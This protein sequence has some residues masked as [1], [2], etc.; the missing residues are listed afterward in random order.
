MTLSSLMTIDSNLIWLNAVFIL[1]FKPFT[2]GSMLFIL[3]LK[4][5]KIHLDK[6]EIF[7]ILML[8]Y[9]V[10]MFFEM[11]LNIFIY[12]TLEFDLVL[13][14][15]D[16][17]ISTST[18]T[19]TNTNTNTNTNDNIPRTRD[20]PDYARLIRYLSANIG[21]LASKRPVTRAIGLTIANAGNI[22]ADIASNEE[23]ANYW[24]DQYN[25]YKTNGRFRGGQPGSGPF[26]RGSNPFD[27][28]ANIGNSDT[29]NFMPNFEFIRD[30]LSPVEHSIPLDTL[31][32]VHFI[33]ILGLFVI[34]CALILLT[35]YVYIQILI[36][37][38]KDFILN[39]IKNRYAVM[40]VKYVLFKSRV[41]II[42]MSIFIL[43]TLCFMVY[44]LHY[45]IVHPIV[46][47]T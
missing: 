32:N 23:R 12:D 22:L 18:S 9:Q 27:D 39:K 44:I 16:N 43:A 15:A 35:A 3:F 38:N 10:G 11:I 1:I 45:L 13:K 4:K 41:D 40:Y 8:I 6:L 14:M 24:I 26:E 47:K 31:I 19:S 21:A 7:L 29:T 17:N 25:F 33:M 30:L 37:F 34:T 28:P 42:V 5:S 36:V 20:N 2:I 46:V